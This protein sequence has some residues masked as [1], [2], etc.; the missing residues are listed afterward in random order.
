MSMGYRN[1]HLMM[2]NRSLLAAQPGLQ[3][4]DEKEEKKVDHDSF[5]LVVVKALNAFVQF[6]EMVY[7]TIGLE[8]GVPDLSTTYP[9]SIRPVHAYSIQEVRWK[10]Y[11]HLRR[12]SPA[13]TAEETTPEA[14]RA[15][16]SQWGTLEKESRE[17]LILCT[18]FHLDDNILHPFAANRDLALSRLETMP[19]GS[20]LVR[21]SSVGDAE[22]TDPVSRK[23]FPF[24]RVRVVSFRSVENVVG[25]LLIAH[26]FGFGWVNFTGDMDDLR[27]R[28][29]PPLG[30][31]RSVEILSAFA[32]A[33]ELIAFLA[34]GYQ[35]DMSMFVCL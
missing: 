34:E 31:R 6:E 25:H 27:A 23:K 2:R 13:I 30:S 26:I 17:G 22:W 18:Q 3:R 19:A 24:A 20:Y 1:A 28:G 33:V 4:E 8:E 5:P 10:R 35:F 32:S 21:P 11:H 7:V 16:L 29:F 12:L 15:L 14:L 9:D